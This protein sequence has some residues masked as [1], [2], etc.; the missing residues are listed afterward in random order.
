MA[1]LTRASGAVDR[2]RAAVDAV[3]AAYAQVLF[4]RS[5]VT[6]ALLLLATAIEPRALAG[7]LLAVTVAAA[8]TRLLGL[9]EHAIERGPHGYNALLVGLSVG[10]RFGV[11]A[12]AVALAVGAA[13][14]TVLV[15]AALTEGAERVGGG[16]V[17]SLPFVLVCWLTLGV[18]SPLG[19]SAVDAPREPRGLLAV[20][21]ALFFV[22]RAD[23]GA[24]VLAALLWHSRIA[25]LLA[26]GCAALAGALGAACPAL[27]QPPIGAAI[28]LNAMLTAVAVGG[29]WFVPS[30]SSF[31]LGAAGALASL[32]VT[33]GLA[34]A[35]ARVGLPLL[36]LPFNA[37]VWLVLYAARRRVFDA[38]PKSVD[39]V[40][41]SPEDN[42]A[43]YRT[44][45]ARFRALYAVAFRLPFRG[46]WVCTQGVDGRFTHQGEWRH[47]FDFEV[48]D[49]DGRFF[50]GAGT[51]IEDHHCHRLPV[52]AAADG[53]VVK[54][55]GDVPDNAPGGLDLERNWGNCVVVRHAPGLH[56]LVA[57][58]ARG[59]VSVREGQPVRRGDV[60]GACGSS[61][62]S[63]RPHLHFQLQSTAALGAPTLPCR[64]T[65]A[66]VR[67]RDERVALAVSPAEGDVVRNVEPDEA[68]ASLL[69]FEPAATLAFRSRGSIEHVEHEIDLL[70]NLVLR[71]R[72]HG[73][74]LCFARSDDGF[75]SY[76]PLGPA[77][78]V[79]HLLRA[80]LSRVPFDGAPDLVWTDYLSPRWSARGGLG[81]L[82]SLAA[83]FLPGPGLEMRYRLR[84]RPD[85]VDVLGESLRAH[86][87]EPAVRTIAA[88]RRGVGVA[89]LEVRAAGRALVAER[90]S[91]DVEPPARWSRELGVPL[92]S[93]GGPA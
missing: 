28:T 30:P 81:A 87:G 27:G 89:R 32:G 37:S 21:G 84:R 68:L 71:S 64:F 78:S 65:D 48:R 80:A 18:A 76:D 56:S 53:V 44:R 22:P 73:A 9:G 57:H 79:L 5:R 10:H 75:T 55:V 25:S 92:V 36:I 23:A 67:R 24:L 17:L 88:L 86:G 85:G 51:A 46:A 49:D 33:V 90:L 12:P 38:R 45:L 15:T 35:V 1:R 77:A 34:S 91:S 6:G 14:V 4:S 7:G 3:L 29:V 42:L 60:L 43:Y 39:F 40:P 2:A 70:G 16:P 52:L 19:L 69:A 41:G 61:G 74:T 59:S 72:E 13:V 8:A 47:A 31:A 58:L 54:V 66:I 82:L 83:P 93:A 20:L 26:L 63:P 62:R 50:K 11:A